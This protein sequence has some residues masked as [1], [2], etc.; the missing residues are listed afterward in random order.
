M[1]ISIRVVNETSADVFRGA[2]EQAGALANDAFFIMPH[3]LNGARIDGFGAFGFLADDENGLAEGGSFFLDTARIGDDE[4]G[5]AQQIDEGDVVE[6]LNEL[7]V[8]LAA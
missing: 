6:G 8:G 3:Q 7:D 1:A 4:V 5:G 2:I